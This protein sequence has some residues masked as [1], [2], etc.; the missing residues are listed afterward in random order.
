M[1][2]ITLRAARTNCDLT[3]KQVADLTGKCA[4]TLGKYERDSS[5]IPRDVMEDLIRIYR[6]P[7][8]HIFFGKESVFTERQK[9]A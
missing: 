2:L 4:E 8:H 1:L 7:K 9:M 3:L 5:K 6:I